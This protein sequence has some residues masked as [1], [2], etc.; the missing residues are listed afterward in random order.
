[1]LAF[2]ETLNFM[3]LLASAFRECEFFVV[4]NR[5]VLLLFLV[6]ADEP[7]ASNLVRVRVDVFKDNRRLG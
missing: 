6:A 4:A 2:I 1:M 5:H 3:H 7:P